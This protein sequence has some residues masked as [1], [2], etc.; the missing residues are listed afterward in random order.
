ML[1]HRRFDGMKITR[2]LGNI[3]SSLLLIVLFISVMSINDL[4]VAES[5][6]DISLQIREYTTSTAPMNHTGLIDMMMAYDSESDMTLIFGGIDYENPSKIVDQT[7]AYDLNSDSYLNMSPDQSPSP[8]AAGGMVYDSQNDRSILFGGLLSL[9]TQMASDQTWL[10]DYNTNNWTNESPTFAPSPRF[11]MYLTYDS[12]S[13]RVIL[14]GGVSLNPVSI[15]HNDT[16]A[17]DLDSNTWEEMNPS[18][19]PDARYG[20]MTSYDVE[21][22]R[23]ILFGGNPSATTTTSTFSDSW[24]YDYNTDR[25]VE[26]SPIIHPSSRYAGM[27][28]YDNESNKTVLF[29]GYPSA[30]SKDNTWL[31]DYGYN[32]WTQANPNPHPNGRFRQAAVYDSESDSIIMFGGMTGDWFSEQVIQTDTTWVYDTDSDT[33]AQIGSVP[34]LTTTTTTAP[35]VPTAAMVAVVI[36]TGLILAVIIIVLVVKGVVFPKVEI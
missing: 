25:W 31:F 28:T 11:A 35:A 16:W 24:A 36:I 4:A 27:M 5:E 20:A 23:V 7:W 10:Y 17:Y 19:A 13:D 1:K 6:M 14:F 18:S 21:N 3:F 26:L 8:R 22:D 15:V 34:V 33:W 30:S 29:G 9:T 2:K 32:N 12:E